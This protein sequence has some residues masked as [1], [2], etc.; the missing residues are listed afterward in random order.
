L[1]DLLALDGEALVDRLCALTADERAA[2]YRPAVDAWERYAWRDAIDGRE[3]RYTHEQGRRLEMIVMGTAPA[4]RLYWPPDDDDMRIA[5]SRGSRFL[6]ALARRALHLMATD[7]GGPEF[8]KIRRAERDGLITVDADDDYVLAMV[9]HLAGRFSDGPTRADL[10]RADPDL[11]ARA[12]WRIFTIEGNRQVSLANVD[13]YTGAHAQTW[14][15]AVLDLLSDNTIDRSRV[16]DATIAALGLG[17]PAY[18]AGWYS[19]L[20]AALA[21]S[22]DELTARQA[23]YTT[24]LR[25]SVGPTVALAVAALTAVEKAGRLDHD[26]VAAGLAAAVLAPAKSTAT[27]ALALAIRIGAGQ[28]SAALTAALGHPHPDVQAVAVQHFRVRGEPGPVLSALPALAPAVAAAARRW[29]GDTAPPAVTETTPPPEAGASIPVLEAVAPITDPAE[30]AEAFAVLLADPTDA[31]LLERALCAAARL[32]PDPDEYA[33]LARRAARL[34]RDGPAYEWDLLLDVVA[35]VVFAAAHVPPPRPL[36]ALTPHVQH[37]AGRAAEVESALR[38]ARRYAPC[39]EP[40]HA[41]GWIAPAVLVERLSTGPAPDRLD[42][43]AAL[44]RLGPDPASVPAAIRDAAVPGAVGTALRYALGGPPPAPLTRTDRPLWIAAARSRAP[45]GDDPPLIGRGPGYDA[46]GAGRAPAWRVAL[47]AERPYNKIR[48]SA[49]G[50][51]ASPAPPDPALPT[52]TLG[53]MDPSSSGRLPSAPWHPWL[54]SVWPGNIEP[55][56]AIALRQQI[57]SLD[58]SVDGGTGAHA[59]HLLTRT[60]VELPPLS[61]YTVATGLAGANVSDRTVAVDAAAALLPQRMNPEALASA[62]ATLAPVVPLNRWAASLG[63]LATAG[64]GAQVRAVLTTLLPSLDQTTR[65]LH[66]LVELLRDEQLRAGAPVTAPAL[67]QWLTAATGKSRTATAARSLL[68]DQHNHPD[69][70]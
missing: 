64:R 42:A 55:L 28:P 36:P 16:L 17:F 3:Y 35:G 8:T 41:G 24:L 61:V 70:S 47:D 54:A 13:K 65:G 1:T 63:D 34:L 7:R 19:R 39:A 15:E 33:G 25:S 6:T 4:D 43:V 52:V 69:P 37:L 56:L 21:P 46:A 48:V 20:H 12:F 50:P 32:G 59:L 23:G 66:T 67:R 31:Q 26:G 44:L 2:L 27:K 9:N 62:M 49:L 18:R 30:L 10:L 5:R 60:V 38:S 22:I 51:A 45:R 58:G 40:T 57:V 29:L 14:H 68:A 11:L 53:S